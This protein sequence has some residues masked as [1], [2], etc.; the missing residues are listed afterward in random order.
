MF[1][2]SHNHTSRIRSLQD[3]NTNKDNP[4]EKQEVAEVPED[5]NIGAASTGS[6][7]LAKLSIA[8]VVAATITVI[9]I[10]FKPSGPGSSL[11]V[12]CLAEGSSTLA[13][14]SP[15][16]FTFKAFGYRFVIP[17]YAPGYVLLV[18]NFPR[19]FAKCYN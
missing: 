17:E 3:E 7:F 18:L 16:G 15:V 9:S 4:E 12:Q 5:Q 11:G 6:S 8:L 19:M 13:M 2:A 14:A 1:N 10:G